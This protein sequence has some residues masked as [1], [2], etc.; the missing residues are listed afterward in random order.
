MKLFIVSLLA[1][2]LVSAKTLR[3][4]PCA[5]I[6]RGKDQACKDAC[7]ACTDCQQRGM[8]PHEHPV[9]FSKCS[10]DC[11]QYHMRDETA[12]TRC[13]TACGCAVQRCPDGWTWTA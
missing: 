3:P 13:Y 10:Y 11:D 6:C 8:P 9:P 4:V 1:L 2:S 12:L 7:S 5:S